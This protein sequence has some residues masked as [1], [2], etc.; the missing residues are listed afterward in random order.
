MSPVRPHKG[1]PPKKPRSIAR[2]H[3]RINLKHW[4]R[5]SAAYDRR[6][7]RVLSGRSAM[8]W[9]FWR[10]PESRLQLLGP[11]KGRD[12]LEMGCGA[13]RWSIAL[14]AAGARGIGIDIS[15]SQLAKARTLARRERSR[16]A[17]V[18]GNAESLPFADAS[19]DIV[20]CDWGAMTFCDPYRTVPEAARVLRPGGRFVFSTS[21]PFRSVVQ[22]RVKGGMGT[23]LRYDYFG[24][25]EIEYRNEVNFSL[26]Y[27][28]WIRLFGEFHLTVRSLTELSPPGGKWSPY[29]TAAEE[30]WARR[31]PLESI[32]QTE[33]GPG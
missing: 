8:S 14:S 5:T 29:L 22:D 10:V 27:G 15:S 4:E 16:V 11:V 12:V 2:P 23:K 26:P 1:A 9:G 28:A 21:S 13:A 6:C 18:R 30:S 7:A 31:W 20:F 17:L 3:I 33:K 24:L 19:F 25:H 32:W